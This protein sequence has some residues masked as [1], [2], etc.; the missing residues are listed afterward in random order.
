MSDPNLHPDDTPELALRLATEKL[1]NP[2][3]VNRYF[4]FPMID[5]LDIALG[6][7]RFLTAGEISAFR[8][9]YHTAISMDYETVRVLR[10]ALTTILEALP[11]N[12]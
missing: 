7:S 6:N 5:R 1:T 3:S 8:L 12:G 10:D 2:S 9:E 4:A 11:Q